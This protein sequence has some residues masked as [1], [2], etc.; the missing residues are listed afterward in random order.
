MNDV[1]GTE[2]QIRFTRDLEYDSTLL[3]LRA[4]RRLN[5]N[6]SLEAKLYGFLN[7]EDD[8]ALNAFRDDHRLQL[9]LIR[10]F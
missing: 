4:S 9:N 1:N 6:W 5:S 2:F 7:V 8:P 10:R 3:D